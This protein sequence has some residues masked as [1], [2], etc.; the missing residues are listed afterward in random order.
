MR[1]ELKL[2]FSK[3]R[4]NEGRTKTRINEGRTKTCLFKMENK[5]CA[6]WRKEEESLCDGRFCTCVKLLGQF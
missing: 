3:W 5:F 1:K 2:A 4:I 6:G